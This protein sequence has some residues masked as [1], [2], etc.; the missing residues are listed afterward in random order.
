MPK[1]VWKAFDCEEGALINTLNQ[2]DTDDYVPW[3]LRYNVE[4]R[5]SQDPIN[6]RTVV[7]IIAHLKSLK[8]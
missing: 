4:V 3:E 2:L 6:S 1:Q 5:D 8:V 7:R